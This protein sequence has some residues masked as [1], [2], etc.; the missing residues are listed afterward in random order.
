MHRRKEKEDVCV[1]GSFSSPNHQHRILTK[2]ERERETERGQSL[3]EGEGATADCPSLPLPFLFMQQTTTTSQITLERERKTKTDGNTAAD[4]LLATTSTYNLD[5][6]E[7]GK[8]VPLCVAILAKHFLCHRHF[9]LVR[10]KTVA[11]NYIMPS[12]SFCLPSSSLFFSLF[13]SLTFSVGVRQ[14]GK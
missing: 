12:C 6:E 11:R 1:F 10:K 8:A 5:E 4:T 3:E 14:Q 13:S 2:K 7:G 9:G